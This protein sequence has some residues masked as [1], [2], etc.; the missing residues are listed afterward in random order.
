MQGGRSTRPMLLVSDIHLF[1]TLPAARMALTLLLLR[2]FT[3]HHHHHCEHQ[4]EKRQSLLPTAPHGGVTR[5]LPMSPACVQTRQEGRDTRPS[6]HAASASRLS[7][8]DNP[9]KQLCVEPEVYF[10]SISFASDICGAPRERRSVRHRT[11]GGN[12]TGAEAVVV[13][14]HKIQQ[15]CSSSSSSSF[16]LVHLCVT[17]MISW[18]QP[19]SL[20]HPLRPRHEEKEEYETPPQ[21]SLTSHRTVVAELLLLPGR[22]LWIS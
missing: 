11:Y 9:F 21:R 10:L 5:A 8:P 18:S 14:R 20:S 6:G 17:G 1:P 3:R 19:P 22:G 12:M 15:I 13:H 4:E 7:S 2:L 16:L